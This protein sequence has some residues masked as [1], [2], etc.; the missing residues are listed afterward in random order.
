MRPSASVRFSAAASSNHS[1]QAE[2][3]SVMLLLKPALVASNRAADHHR[4]GGLHVEAGRGAL[5]RPEDAACR[6]RDGHRRGADAA[7]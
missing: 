2:S 3:E 7:W 1:D 6:A 4:A 5:D